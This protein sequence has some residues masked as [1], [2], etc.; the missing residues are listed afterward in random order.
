VTEQPEHNCDDPPESASAD[1]APHDLTYDPHRQDELD[2]V[3]IRQLAALKRGAYRARSFAIIGCV[4]SFVVA[5]KL[6]L[7]TAGHVQARGWGAWPLGFA[8]SSLV[9]MMLGSY[10]GRRAM[11]LHREINTPAPLPPPPPGGPDFSTLSDGSQQW[12]NLEDIR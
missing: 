1:N 6:A 7:M 9:A 5:V 2:G 10:F 4:A 11:D 8:S 12:K 3:R